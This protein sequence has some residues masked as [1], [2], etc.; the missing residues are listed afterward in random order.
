[1]TSHLAN[2]EGRAVNGY[3]H[4]LEKILPIALIRAHTKTDDIPAVT[5]EQLALYRRAA[6]E[7]AQKYTGL[8]LFGTQTVTEAVKLPSRYVRSG[9]IRHN[10]AHQFAKPYAHFI[11]VSKQNAIEIMVDVGSQTAIL[12]Q[13]HTDLSGDCCIPCGGAAHGPR[14]IY[15]A[16]YA[17]ESDIPAAIALGC[18]KY[19]AHV[20][21][22]PGDLVY[23]NAPSGRA[24][25]TAAIDKTANP[26]WASGAIEIWRSCVGRAI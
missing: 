20:I 24:G 18:L 8:F 11:P 6:I 26:A 21:E 2:A 13:T 3:D 10:T 1:M 12:P 5:D 4:D 22:N 19:I 15:V 17:C 23:A 14:L 25:D 7:A 16:G 9:Y